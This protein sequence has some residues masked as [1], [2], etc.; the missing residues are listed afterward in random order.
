MVQFI[1]NTFDLKSDPPIVPVM[2][3]LM[4]TEFSVSDKK[5][6]EELGYTNAI[7]IEE[8]MLTLV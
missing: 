8:G 6:R 7:T 1:W 3:H 4:G 2:V 5:A